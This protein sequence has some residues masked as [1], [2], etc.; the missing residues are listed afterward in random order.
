MTISKPDTT[1]TDTLIR[2]VKSNSIEAVQTFFEDH[3]RFTPDFKEVIFYAPNKNPDILKRLIH[4]GADV[5]VQD[6]NGETPLHYAV[7]YGAKEN[8]QQLLDAGA[9]VN[10]RNHDDKTPLYTAVLDDDRTI[11]EL[12]MKHGADIDMKNEFQ[13]TRLELAAAY[14]R[15]D[16]ARV[17]LALGADVNAVNKRGDT[18]LHQ[19]LKENPDT[20]ALLIENG[21]DP[22]LKDAEG[23]PP[24]LIAIRNPDHVKWLIQAG[25]DVNTPNNEGFTPLHFAAWSQNTAANGTIQMLIDLGADVN[26]VTVH[27]NTPLHLAA[28]YNFPDSAKILLENSACTTMENIKGKTPAMCALEDVKALLAEHEVK[29]LQEGLGDLSPPSKTKGITL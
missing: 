15:V 1:P 2:A 10:A 20:V 21:A 13:C 16:E 25:A 3:P 26:A 22:N 6:G 7:F 17:L 11:G 18:P 9:K 27:G 12:L 19:A 24:L 29:I 14:G 23:N 4:E 5:N 8:V 28:Q